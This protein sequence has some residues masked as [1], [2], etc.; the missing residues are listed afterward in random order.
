MKKRA[1]EFDIDALSDDQLRARYQSL[2]KRFADAAR[3]A[4]DGYGLGGQKIS[5]RFVYSDRFN[6]CC[7]INEGSYE[8]DI[9]T[10]IPVLTLLFFDQLF[11]CPR[12]MKWLPGEDSKAVSYDVQFSSGPHGLSRIKDWSI[13]TSPLRAYVAYIASEIASTFVLM[14][15]LG[16]VLCGHLQARD[17]I[18]GDPFIAEFSYIGES[19]AEDFELGQ[20]FEYEADAA[21]AWLI[22]QY[23]DE[24]VKAA[25]EDERAQKAFGFDRHAAER[26]VAFCVIVLYAL[27]AYLKVLKSKFSLQSSHP[28]P[29]VR[30]FYVRDMIWKVAKE[31]HVLD[32]EVVG[33]MLE[34]LFEEV[35]SVLVRLGL[36]SE[37]QFEQDLDFDQ[38]DM[39]VERL[40]AAKAKYREL[41]NKFSFVPWG[42]PRMSGTLSSHI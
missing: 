19:S 31:R 14:H 37:G 20:L 6:A 40:K 8:V 17:A 33:E 22:T 32:D 34:D 16:H 41:S 42:L 26:S 36:Q 39:G 30:A 21:A 25:N 38:I 3:S 15:E 7:R 27:F 11:S 1:A 29:L 2:R 28:D 5:F 4:E 13:K 9:A 35:N 23:V 24:L 12:I 18:Y 10:A